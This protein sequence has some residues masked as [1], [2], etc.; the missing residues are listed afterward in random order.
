MLTVII[1]GSGSG[2]SALLPEAITEGYILPQWRF[3]MMS[4][5]KEWTDIVK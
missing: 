3:L 1:G 2:K 5:E 4:A